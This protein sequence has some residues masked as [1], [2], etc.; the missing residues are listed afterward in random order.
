[1]RA[2]HFQCFVAA[3]L[4]APR[5]IEGGEKAPKVE[6]EV[7]G[8]SHF[9]TKAPPGCRAITNDVLAH[10]GPGHGAHP[11]GGTEETSEGRERIHPHIHQGSTA[12]RV[13]PHMVQGEIV[14]DGRGKELRACERHVTD[15]PLAQQVLPALRGRQQQRDRGTGELDVMRACRFDELRGI[16]HRLRQRFLS[17]YVSASLQRSHGDR[18]MGLVRRQI[19]DDFGIALAQKTLEVGVVRARAKALLGCSG[20]LFNAVTDGDQGG[21]VVQTVELREIDPLRHLT[22]SHHTDTHR[23]HGPDSPLSMSLPRGNR[24]DHV[25]QLRHVYWECTLQ[26]H[27]VGIR[28]DTPKIAMVHVHANLARQDLTVRC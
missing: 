21:L 5:D 25:C 27:Q 13:I 7:H 28:H 16:V 10:D 9:V 14:P 22:A 23:T 18:H 3:G 15:R 20:P 19:D 2:V 24:I 12:G 26:A 17:I 8:V 11:Q 1:M 4:H 6:V